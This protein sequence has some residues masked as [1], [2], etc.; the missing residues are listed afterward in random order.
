[1]QSLEHAE[2]INAA[3]LA[4][5]PKLQDMAD[6]IA[7][8]ARTSAP[9]A[10]SPLLSADAA[11]E[12][13]TP[14]VTADEIDAALDPALLF[15][16]DETD[17]KDETAII[18]TRLAVAAAGRQA[19]TPG[20]VGASAPA[21]GAAAAGDSRDAAAAGDDRDTAA[22][23]AQAPS[24]GPAAAGAGDDVEAQATPEHH[25]VA[26]REMMRAVGLSPRTVQAALQSKSI[27]VRLHE[28]ALAYALSDTL[29][30]L[31]TPAE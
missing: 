28:T 13:G 25:R 6:V 10:A 18:R 30:P 16:E 23:G 26:L 22:V 11:V 29:L 19:D 12:Q 3:L 1:M 5:E 21:A 14:G 24:G 15:E 20:G 8:A 9:Q 31:D 4:L 27:A 2:G 17:E 7:A